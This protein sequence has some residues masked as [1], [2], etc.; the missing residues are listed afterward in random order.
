MINK[1]RQ[2][3]EVNAR[4]LVLALSCALWIG[5]CRVDRDRAC[6]SFGTIYDPETAACICPPATTWTPEDDA[7][8][9]RCAPDDAGVGDAGRPTDG[10]IDARADVADDGGSDCGELDRCAGVAECVDLQTDEAHCGSCERACG[11]DRRCIAGDCIDAVIQVSVGSEHACATRASGGVVC[12]GRNDRGQLGDGTTRDATRPVAVAGLGERVRNVAAG[13]NFTCA[14]YDSGRVG[15]WGGNEYAQLGRGGAEDSD[16]H[17]DVA[18]VVGLADAESLSSGV[19]H[20][21]AVRAGGSLVCWGANPYGQLGVGRDLSNRS[22]P[23]AVMAGV[24][25]VSAGAIHSCAAMTTGEARCWGYNPH[26]QI[27]DGGPFGLSEF[28]EYP[29]AVADLAGVTS[30]VAGGPSTCATVGTALHCWGSNAVGQLAQGTV[31]TPMTSN[32]PLAVT[33]DPVEQMASVSYHWCAALRGGRV[34]CWGENRFGQLGDGSTMRRGAPTDVPVP[35]AVYV[36]G[37]VDS[38]C[39]ALASGAVSCWGRNNYGQLGNGTLEDS[40]VPVEV[41]GIP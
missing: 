1:R 30:I 5:G 29:V 28:R 26:G 7:G 6:E 15:C 12:W 2:G 36:G 17:A 11:D 3:P 9:Y 24:R 37:G 4:A 18:Q 38:S 10:G 13:G 25:S 14:L 39:A 35:P 27:G 41:L 40:G 34:Q 8:H 21:C 20:V 22:T 19:A 16:P 32:V 23:V 33:I 31:G